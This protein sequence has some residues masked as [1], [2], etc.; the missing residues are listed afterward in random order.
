MIVLVFLFF[1]KDVTWLISTSFQIKQFMKLEL[2]PSGILLIM[3][4]LWS[5][6]SWIISQL[7][8]AYTKERVGLCFG[9]VVM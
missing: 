6:R 5:N 1:H 3:I 4:C 7:I 2:R 9:Y 8:M